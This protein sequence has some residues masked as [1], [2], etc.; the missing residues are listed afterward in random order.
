MEPRARPHPRRERQH[1]SDHR[2]HQRATARQG[3]FGADLTSPFVPVGVTPRYPPPTNNI[4]GDREQSWLK[5]DDA[6]RARAQVHVRLVARHRRSSASSVQVQI[7]NEVGQAIDDGL[8]TS[9]PTLEPL[10][11]RSSWCSRLSASCCNYFSRLLPAQDRV[12]HRVRP[13]EHHL[14]APQPHVVLV[15]RPR[16]VGPAHLACQLRHPRRCR[17]TWRSRRASSCSAASRSSR[18]R[19]CCRSTF[20]SRSWRCRRCRSCSSSASRCAEADVPGVVAHPVPPGR[21]RDRR[22][23]EHQRRAGREVVRGRG[24]SSCST[25][26]DRRD[27]GRVGQHRGRRHPGPWS[28][29]I[30]NLP[31]LGQALVLLYGGYLAINGQAT[32]GD[33]VAFNAYVLMLAAAVPPARA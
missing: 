14:R 13:A 2:L 20:R 16:A 23:R 12:P 10:R 9:G 11:D 30:E 27:A 21:R 8:K 19:R 1:A 22:R 4:G 33:I 6:G 26:P 3:A 29:L 7:P 32:V 31:R 24:R 5:R 25:S 18:S 15:L 17:C 28:P